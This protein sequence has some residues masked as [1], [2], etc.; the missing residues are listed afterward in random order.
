[1]FT[2]GRLDVS[3]SVR[4]S[5]LYTR[6]ASLINLLSCLCPRNVH[7][8][9]QVMESEGRRIK[10]DLQRLVYGWHRLEGDS[11]HIVSF[12]YHSTGAGRLVKCA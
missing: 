7:A 1:M 3:L 12:T 11:V 4:C 10:N 8:L 9:L 6:A 5:A 2:G